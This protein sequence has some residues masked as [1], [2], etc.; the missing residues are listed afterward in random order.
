MANLL[1][2]EACVRSCAYC[3]A[4]KQMTGVSAGA[5]LSWDNLIH[6]A[7][8]LEASG[9]RQV[10]LLGGEPSLHPDIVDFVLYL[11]ERDF[12][13]NVFT[14]GI[15]GDQ[16]LD[17]AC[18]YL[19]GLDPARLSFVVNANDPA[20]SP[21]A[22]NQSVE[23]F[24]GLMSPFTQLGF[25]IY[26]P[27]F[28]L[29]FI[30]GYIS[31]FGLKRGLRLGLANP[32]PGTRN[33]HIGQEH[34]AQVARRLVSYAPAFRQYRVRPG[35]DCGFPFCAFSPEELGIFFAVAGGNL[36][37]SCGPAIDIGPDLS[38]WSCFPLSNIKR[39]SLHDFMSMED[40][41]RYYMDFHAAARVEAGGVFDR[42]DT[43]WHR[44][45]EL[46][47][48]GCLGHIVAR[49]MEEPPVRLLELAP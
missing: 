22:E 4:K 10:S 9:D 48:G 20:D 13:V 31:R 37:F 34:F 44:E 21:F 18:R 38:L 16:T 41:H 1:L 33:A 47:S 12:H 8:F 32:I 40:I 28:D 39:T 11:Y 19:S 36:R 15:M 24:L 49:V 29:D 17:A 45:E 2:T 14:S 30:F 42:C 5:V 43:C 27:D 7:D 3:F 23:R 6:A 26:R 25:N 35:F 46:C